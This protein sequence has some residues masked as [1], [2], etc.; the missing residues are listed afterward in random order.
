MSRCVMGH[1]PL[2]LLAA[3]ADTGGQLGGALLNTQV[4]QAC[5]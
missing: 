1:P 3:P 2:A 5:L 4:H